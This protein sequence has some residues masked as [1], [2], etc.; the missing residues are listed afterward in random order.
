MKKPKNNANRLFSKR[1]IY[2]AILFCLII[3]GIL[4]WAE[5]RNTNLSYQITW[6]YRT[7]LFLGLGFVMMVFRDLAYIIRIRILT[8]KKLSWKQSFNTIM[9][10]EFASALSPGVVGG[11]AAAI[12]ILQRE[13]IKLGKATTFVICTAIL[14]NL[15]YIILIPCTLFFIPTESLFPENSDWLK[16]GGRAAFWIGYSS[17]VFVNLLLIS[18]VFIQPK[19]IAFVVRLIYRLPFLRQK[20]Q[21]GEQLIKDV[22]KASKLLKK[23]SLLY[24]I[25]LF[26]VTVWSW[27]SRFAVINCVLFA[28]LSLNWFDNLVILVRQ[29]MMWVVMLITPTPGGSG[30]AE[31][32]F[33]EIYA[34][35]V[36]TIGI[37]GALLAIIWRIISYY[38]Y[39]IIGSIILPKWLART[40][41]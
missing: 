6:T 25:R 8:K 18:S 30:M 38:P 12:F 10:W 29:L 27:I 4:F 33:T 15:F 26:S 24:W 20:R 17:I 31:F 28:F 40:S 19:I 7:F 11:S 9:L 13:N 2:L 22:K 16:A 23:E 14:D 39:L 1:R 5:T 37:S 34:D 41:D 35:Y 36:F 32:L 21:K 3:T